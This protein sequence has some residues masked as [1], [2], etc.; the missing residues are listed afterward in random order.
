MEKINKSDLEIQKEITNLADDNILSTFHKLKKM[1]KRL[2]LFSQ[3]GEIFCV[4][5]PRRVSWVSVT[6]GP[7]RPSHTGFCI[8]SLDEM[9]ENLFE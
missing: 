5:L 1:R 6:P 2:F 4:L 7:R 3:T 8:M 9:C